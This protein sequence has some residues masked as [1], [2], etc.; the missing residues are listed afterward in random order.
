MTVAV[1]DVGSKS[2]KLLVAA[3]DASGHVAALAQRAFDTCLGAGLGA[4]APSLG[5]AGMAAGLDAIQAL[6]ALA[7][8]FE[9]A[10]T[11][12]VATS[13]VRDAANGR[14]FRSRV[15]AATSHEL[16][17]LSGEEEAGLIGRG[18]LCDPALAELRDFYVFDL[19]GGSLECLA[20]RDRHI[21][22]ALSLP[23]GCVRM[24]EK[25]FP[26]TDERLTPGA[27]SRVA[28][29]V[30]NTLKN[31]GFRFALGPAPAVFTGGSVATVRAIT[32]A[33][34][35]VA[36]ADTPPFV[37]AD[38]LSALIEEVMPLSLAARKKIPGLPA[39]RAD[40]FPAALITLLAVAELGPFKFFYHSLHNLRWG[41]AAEALDSAA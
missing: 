1:I 30:R 18:L 7:A 22:Q 29:H 40:V 27:C 4:D 34:H 36:F 19:G 24:T 28:V 3:R 21:A 5:E 17:I 14:D 39:A 32:G 20:F 12:L 10:K 11:I 2:I 6:L 9:P 41:L 26:A 15:L 13:A 35:H 33:M 37:S 31:S 23:L 25:F 16:R 8:E 38:T